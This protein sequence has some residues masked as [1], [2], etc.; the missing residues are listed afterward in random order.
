MR[1]VVILGGGFSG[2]SAARGI[3]RRLDVTVVSQDN[4]LLF[5]PMLAEAAVGDVDP[6]HIV[7]PIRQLAPHARL[8]QGV[9]ER[10]EAERR[11]IVIRP[12]FGDGV[13]QLEADNI[14]FALGSVPNTFGVPGVEEHALP[15]KEIGDALR[16]RNR[17]LALL[18]HST[19]APDPSLT[20]V[21]V[22]GAGYSGA[23]IS[24]ALADFLR[25][26]AARFYDEAPPPA[27]ILVDAVPRVTPALSPSLSAAAARALGAR[28]VELALGSAV[29]EVRPGGITLA[30]GRKID[31]ATVIWAAGVKPNPLVAQ[32]GLPVEK[33]RLVVDGHL[34]VSPGI[35]AIG[36]VA[37]VEAGEG[38]SPPTAQFALRQG[39]YLG[40]YL[41]DLVNGSK[42]VPEFRYKTKGELVSLGH[43]NAVGR[44]LGVPVSGFIGWFLWRTYYLWQLPSGLRKARVALDWTLDLL[45]PPDIAWIPSSDLGPSSRRET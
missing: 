5:T 8:V 45:F 35:F 42:T 18:E 20:R 32:S 34:Q 36:D 22:I 41:P 6:R 43:R 23:E 10:V 40:R 25:P 27:V 24:G 29:T 13:M 3:G 37:R 26:A 19:Q 38:V 4:F 28:G 31:A 12:L 16:I 2:T 17:L 14:I 7:T 9:V 33:G 30:S 1:R 39:R 11:S 21:V 15:F 44:T